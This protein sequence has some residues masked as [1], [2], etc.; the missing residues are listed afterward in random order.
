MYAKH[1]IYARIFNIFRKF[2][3]KN[4]KITLLTNKNHSFDSNLEYI[5][6]ELDNRNND[7]KNYEY[8]FIPKDSL[9][10]SDIRDFA[11]SKYV[12]L[13]DNFF[14]LAFMNTNGMK[15][16]QLWHGTGIFKKF[17]YD[18]LNPEEK[19]VM[20]IFSDK[21]DLVSCSGEN[22]RDIYAHNFH[23]DKS[24]VL[25]SGIPRNDFYSEEHMNEAFI[26]G[27]RETFEK[28]YPQLVGKK[29]VLYAPSFRENP[30]NNAVFDYF[31]I[32]KFIEELGDDYA[33]AIRLHPNYA[34]YCDEEHPIDLKDLRDK[35][36]IIDF[37]GFKDEQK[38]L[39]L[40]DIFITD[41]SSIMV[42]Y[43][44]LKKPIL[45]FAYDLDDYLKN[46]RG[47]YFDYRQK[48]P[49]KIVYDIDELIES[50]KDE[51]F[52]M[53]KLEEFSQF[54]FGDFKANASKSILDY[55]LED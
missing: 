55:I 20:E 4:N 31:D 17:G 12:F 52:H 30:T 23:V 2:P 16:I 7:G 43:T 51:D 37:T 32:E 53:E 48:V 35:Y 50:I 28:E 33:L 54:Q 8:K 6:K 13:V 11:T 14:P 41:Y 38:L 29:L 15:W 42:D 24:K 46:E 3:Q 27:L 40:S 25:P 44:I 1:K 26:S 36:D 47:F 10:L 5:A 49:G 21:I 34:S 19:K 18:L 22:V 45:L 39:L 9:S